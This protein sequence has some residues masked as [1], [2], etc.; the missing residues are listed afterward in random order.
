MSLDYPRQSDESRRSK[1]VASLTR[2]PL[3]S[4]IVAHAAHEDS[5]GVRREDAHEVQGRLDL[6]LRRAQRGLEILARG[7]DDEQGRSEFIV[8]L[9]ATFDERQLIMGHRNTLI[10]GLMKLSLGGVWFDT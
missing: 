6:K 10:D 5:H 8:R 1:Y 3:D 2:G 7:S 4:L 9:L